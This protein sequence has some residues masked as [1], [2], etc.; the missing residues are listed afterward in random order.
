MPRRRTVTKKANGRRPVASDTAGDPVEA[1]R[2]RVELL[3]DQELRFATLYREGFAVLAG[4]RAKR[5]RQ[6]L[7]SNDPSG[8]AAEINQRIRAAEEELAA[9]GEAAVE[10]R[11]AR[12][13]AIAAFIAAEADAKERQAEQLDADAAKLEA[14]SDRLREALE[15]HD[16]WGYCV[17]Q[18]K[19]EGQYLPAIPHGDGGFRVIDGR[20]PRHARLRAEAKVLRAQAEQGRYRQP[21]KAGGLEADTVEQLL[22]AVFVD[23]MRIGLTADSIIGWAEQATEKERR[24]R[25]RFDS[26]AD[27]FVP[28][29]APMRFYLEFR[30]G[31]I[32]QAQSRILAPA[33]A[34]SMQADSPADIAK[35]AGS[36]LS[37]EFVAAQG[38]SE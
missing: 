32:D 21:H 3:N 36:P 24:R 37:D 18:G 20:G 12:L 15:R 13:P 28:A 33:G 2:V 16:D 30:Q 14:E 29:A 19:I 9:M 27:A 1:A 26:T 7:D 34:I 38:R 8:A 35:L 6:V 23:A 5:G 17:A 25:A 31:T 11:R 4:I 22:A 10:A